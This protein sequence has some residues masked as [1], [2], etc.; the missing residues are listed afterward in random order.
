MEIKREIKGNLVD[1][2]NR[3]I[4]SGTLVIEAGKI[5]SFTEEEVTSTQYILPGFIDAHIHI[6][7]S[8]LTPYEFAR[9]ALKH[10]TIAT[11]SDPHEIANVLGE[12]GILYM[13]NNA[14]QAKLKFNFGMPSCVPATSF[15]TSGAT[16]NSNSVFQL[17]Q[18]EDILYLSEMMNYPG[19]IYQDAEVISK[20]NYAKLLNKPIDGHAPGLSGD[21]LIAY[22]NA[23]IST[24]HECVSLTEA[25]EKIA[26][27][28]K[29][30]I[31]EGSAAKNYEALK[32]LIQTHPSFCMFCCDDLHPD[33][34]LA[35]HINKHV[36]RAIQDGND[37]MDVLTIACV[38][39]VRHYNL[40]V[41]LLQI[42]DPADFIV[43]DNLIDFTIDSVFINGEQVVQ[44][45]NCLLTDK[46]HDLINH[47]STKHKQIADFKLAA[48]S[49]KVNV[50]EAQDGQLITGSLEFNIESE[51]GN[52]VS[53]INDDILKIAVVNRYQDV[54]PS[55][56]FIKNF[57]LKR[58]AIASSVCHDSHNII[59][60]G[61]DDKSI[62]EAVNLIIDNKG[63][64]SLVDGNLKEI[65]PLP[66]A[67]L[68]SD[69]NAETIG[70]A[71]AKI[72]AQ[73]KELGSKLKAPYMLLSFMG[74]LVIPNL[75]LSDQGLF[76]GKEFKF[77]NVFI[78]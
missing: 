26:L 76:D 13:L 58:G 64:L 75:K 62:A 48:K 66:I 19:V 65:L 71:Y 6:E 72:D 34:L 70:N 24:D 61:V 20:I 15:E 56:A 59:V 45:N 55:I 46:K 16:L 28:M 67:G 14:K 29:I 49:R 18:R 69:H 36:K 7:S 50:I 17:M 42:D 4:K 21:D 78:E 25:L 52:V 9:I 8:M 5:R 27:G 10:G 2:L 68:M 51:D 53:N 43:V 41:G 77:K 54:P 33:E 73:A 11:V 39:P 30:L 74:L 47:F 57:G 44:E 40:N 37:L 63:G 38:N 22:V 60:V 32:S 1:V 3:T 23:G 35:G 31:R 12:E